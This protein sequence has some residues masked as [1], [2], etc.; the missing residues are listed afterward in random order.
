M[1]LTQEQY[2]TAPSQETFDDIKQAAIQMWSTFDNTYGYATE[3]IDRI[4]DLQNVEDNY[5]YI[6]AMFDPRNQI[7]MLKYLESPA[8]LELILKII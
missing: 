5:A 4:K 6:V 3:K 2:Y 7:T 1:K 8:S